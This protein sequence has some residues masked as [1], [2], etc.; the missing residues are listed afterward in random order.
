MAF[1]YFNT[2]RVVVGGR[3]NRGE[4]NKEWEGDVWWEMRKERDIVKKIK[5]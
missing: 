1:I 2:G 3:R 5:R 4:E